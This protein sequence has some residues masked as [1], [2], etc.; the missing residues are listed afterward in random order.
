MMDIG[1]PSWEPA[2]KQGRNRLVDIHAWVLMKNHYHLL[3]SENTERGL[4][5]FI[6]KLNIGYAKYFNERYRRSGALFQGKTKRVLIDTDAHF[7]HIVHYIHLN[8]LDFKSEAREWRS[9]NISKSNDALEYLLKYR[10]S[11]LLDYC[12]RKNFPSV[13][14]KG[15]YDDVYHDYEKELSQHLRE[16]DINTIREYALE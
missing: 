5:R 16:I 6:Q 14:V 9:G 3:L 11:S 10:W 1:S 15:L 8:P 12:N 4:S 2:A 7:L 13:I